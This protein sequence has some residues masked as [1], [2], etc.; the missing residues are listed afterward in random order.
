MQCQ[1]RQGNYTFKLKNIVTGGVV[2]RP[3]KSGSVLD[4]AR[5]IITKTQIYLYNSGDTLSF[6]END[7]GEMHDLSSTSIDDVIP[8]LK[9]NNSL[10]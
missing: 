9:E 8:Y 5:S 10:F 4:K 6:M 7:S 2:N 1:Q 3:F